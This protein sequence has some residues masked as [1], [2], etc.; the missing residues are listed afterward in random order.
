M[1]KFVE[2]II[3]EKNNKF[4]Y[5]E[6]CFSRI[7]NSITMYVNNI[8]FTFTIEQFE[9]FIEDN[10]D[11]LGLRIDGYDESLFDCG[12]MF[13]DESWVSEDNFEKAMDMTF[14]KHMWRVTDEE[15]E[16]GGFYEYL[17]NGHFEPL[18][19]FYTE[20]YNDLDINEILARLINDANLY[21]EINI[22]GAKYIVI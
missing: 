10:F 17:E 7:N 9:S 21:Q 2:D 8:E 13:D 11:Y 14:G 3:N 4:A 16:L 22:K 20:W 12:F 5:L 1:K 6:F 15:N 19:I 18:N